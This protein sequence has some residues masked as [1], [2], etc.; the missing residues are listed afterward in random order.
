M[1]HQQAHDDDART[2]AGAPVAG[3]AVAALALALVR[4]V[5]VDAL[6]LA[7]VRLRATFVNICNIQ[8]RHEDGRQLLVTADMD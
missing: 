8:S 7:A 1:H 2:G 5:R 4:A 3:K 6:M